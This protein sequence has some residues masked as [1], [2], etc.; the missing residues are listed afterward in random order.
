MGVGEMDS[1]FGTLFGGGRRRRRRKRDFYNK[2]P[3][4]ATMCC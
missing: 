3:R 1:K 4:G 2:K